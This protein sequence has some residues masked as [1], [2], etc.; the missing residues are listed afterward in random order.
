MT[1]L[2]VLARAH[3]L[4]CLRAPPLTSRVNLNNQKGYPRAPDLGVKGKKRENS[5]NLIRFK[6]IFLIVR[7]Q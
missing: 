2:Y 1:K 4:H 5:R 3:V 7:G 6:Q